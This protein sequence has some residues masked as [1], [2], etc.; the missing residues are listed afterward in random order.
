MS[1]IV[2]PNNKYSNTTIHTSLYACGRFGNQF[3]RNVCASILAKKYNLKFQYSFFEEFLNMGIKL[4]TEGEITHPTT[5]VLKDEDFERFMEKDLNEDA[6]PTPRN[7]NIDLNFIFLQT[8]TT[9][10]YIR[11]LLIE[12]RDVIKQ[13]NIFRER[14]ENNKDTFVH[15][16]LGD[17]TSVNNGEC[18]TPLEY[19]R[20]T[21]IKI[22]KDPQYWD[23]KIFISSDEIQHPICQSLMKEFNMEHIEMNEGLT[24]QYASTCANLVLSSGTFSWLMGVFGFHSN[25]YYPQIKRVWHGDIFV[26]D[27]WNQE[28][29]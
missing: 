8:P 5:I 10:K 22:Y 29:F 3:I 18:V 1:C 26:F 9:A 21:L 13:H 20:N 2:S 28:M 25:I 27:D 19:Y 17:L 24:I 16:R 6:N 15:L 14:Y 7:H 4:Y 11:N 23:G 12:R